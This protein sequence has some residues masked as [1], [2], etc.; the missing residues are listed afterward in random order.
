MSVTLYEAPLVIPVTG[1]VICDGAVAVRD[2]RVLHVG[3]RD[4]VRQKLAEDVDDRSQVELRR[5]G[6]LVTP[7]LV[8][9]HTHL[10]YTG[11]ASV[12]SRTYASFRDWELA[13]NKIYDTY[14]SFRDWELAFNKIYDSPKPKPWRQ[15]AH[16][17][18]RRMVEAGTTAAADIVSD[19]E[20]AD[21]LAS[22]GMHGIA[23]WEVM[24]WNNED[25]QRKGPEDLLERIHDIRAM[26]VTE[27]GIS[28]HA[29]Y[30]LG[31]G[32][33]LDLPDIARQLGI[34]RR[35][36]PTRRR[37]RG[38]ARSGRASTTSSAPAPAQAPSSSSTSWPSSGRTSTSH[39]ACT[40]RE[41]IAGS[42]ARGAS[43]SRSARAPTASPARRRMRPSR[44]TSRRAT[45]SPSARTRS[46]RAPVSTSW[47][48][49]R[50]CTTLP[51]ARATRSST[52]RTASSG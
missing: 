35:A 28:P 48:T 25:W 2:G 39:T 5:W 3:T 15:W 16:D 19:T 50:S 21:A 14:A 13:F 45:P 12:G 47:T 36:S 44:A 11:M 27:L 7:G 24:D 20:A 52:S 32:P 33:L 43:R 40:H 18:A 22:Q 49:S 30:S 6:G 4:W 23:Y 38:T 1:P 10:Q 37:G 31:S 51:S 29:P 9:A 46:P 34:C 17:G 42:C 26:G 41:K 8:N